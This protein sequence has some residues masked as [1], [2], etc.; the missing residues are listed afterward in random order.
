M[1]VTEA[2]PGTEENIAPKSEWLLDKQSIRP[3]NRANLEGQSPVG[4]TVCLCGGRKITRHCLQNFLTKNGIEVLGGC[5]TEDRL[6]DY[7]TTTVGKCQVLIV[8]PEAGPFGTFH[9]IHNIITQIVDPPNLVVLSEK[10]NRGQVY[11]AL[12]MGAKAYINLDAEPDELINAIIMAARGKAYLSPDAAELLVDDIST[13]V[14][15]QQRPKYRLDVQ[16]SQRELE[17][18]QLLCEGRSSK[19]IG[20]HLHISAKTV[21]NHRYNI[22]RKCDVDGI[23][24]LI[25]HAVQ[26]GIVSL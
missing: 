13:D 3:S 7:L 1:A 14:E 10:A 11:T 23:A 24:S 19:E 21:E 20:R 15:K 4:T 5:E 26:T 22:Y 12:R 6:T 17:V 18:V 2:R 8:L 9:R 16:L 25:R